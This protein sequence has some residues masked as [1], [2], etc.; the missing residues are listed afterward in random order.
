MRSLQAPL[1]LSATK[2]TAFIVEDGSQSDIYLNTQQ[3][4]TP[5]AKDGSNTIRKDWVYSALN[6][7]KYNNTISQIKFFNMQEGKVKFFNATKGFGFITPSNGGPDIF[8]HI[9]G[10]VDEIRRKRHGKLWSPEWKERLKR[11]Q[12][13]EDL[14]SQ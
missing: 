10:T 3:M 13:K 7:Q 1:H 2:D 14:K 11:S 6:V 12:R 9:S 5:P 4:Q 8:V